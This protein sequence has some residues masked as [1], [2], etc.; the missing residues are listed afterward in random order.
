MDKRILKPWDELSDERRHYFSDKESFES[1]MSGYTTP[2]RMPDELSTEEQ[3]GLAYNVQS[4]GNRGGMYLSEIFNSVISLATRPPKPS[5]V[6]EMDDYVS[7]C[8][9]ETTIALWQAVKAEKNL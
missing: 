8:G 9:T 7:R 5:A 3:E 2:L 6:E 4:Y 1:F